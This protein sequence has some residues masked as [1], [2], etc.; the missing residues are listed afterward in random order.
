MLT[1]SAQRILV[2]STLVLAAACDEDVDAESPAL[3]PGDPDFERD[4]AL[5]VENVSAADETR[6]HNAGLNCMRCHQALGPGVGQF[7]VAGTIYGPDGEPASDAMLELR[8]APAGGGE[9]VASV[10][11]DAYGNVF[12]TEPLPLPE[13]P[14]FVRL[15]SSGGVL[16]AAMPFPISSG[17]C[18]HC[19][20]GGFK[21]RLQAADDGGE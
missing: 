15:E 21:V 6:S 9:L 14:L 8:T 10:E 4:P 2:L 17:A 1:H 20:A 12:S 16:A 3:E 5:D 13:Q 18:N 19:H 11:A 7:T